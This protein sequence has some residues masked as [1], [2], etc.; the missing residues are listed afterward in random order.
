MVLWYDVVKLVVR[1]IF[2]WHLSWKVCLQIWIA[3]INRD[4]V[5]GTRQNKKCM[6]GNRYNAISFFQTIHQL[7]TGI[8]N[9]M[10]ANIRIM[11]FHIP[12]YYSSVHGFEYY[13]I[14]TF[15]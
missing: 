12:T 7:E 1:A 3:F 15:F 4:Y 2:Y 8:S 6:K 5:A 14:I 13:R 9:L 11:T 10:L